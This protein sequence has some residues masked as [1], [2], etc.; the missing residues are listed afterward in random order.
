VPPPAHTLR[1]PSPVTC[2]QPPDPD[3]PHGWRKR[4]VSQR[5]AILPIDLRIGP[6]VAAIVGALLTMVISPAV[7]PECVLQTMSCRI[8]KAEILEKPGR[9]Y[10]R[11]TR[12][13]PRGKGKGNR[14]A[15]YERR[16][17]RRAV[18]KLGHPG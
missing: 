14:R 18:A 7:P 10:P 5:R 3:R 2:P 11:R 17:Q 12:R 16:K 6:A 4:H 8:L 13:G 15:Q 1:P 9:S